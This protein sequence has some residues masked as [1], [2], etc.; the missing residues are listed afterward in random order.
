MVTTPQDSLGHL[1]VVVIHPYIRGHHTPRTHV[2][3]PHRGE[4]SHHLDIHNGLGDPPRPFKLTAR[5]H[6]DGRRHQRRQPRGVLQ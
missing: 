4:R 5:L 6:V 2:H 1:S 3:S